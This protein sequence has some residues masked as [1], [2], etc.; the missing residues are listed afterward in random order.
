ME[1]NDVF[2]SITVTF[3][4]CLLSHVLT[5]WDPIDC[6]PQDFSVHGIFQARI[7]EWVSITSPVDFPDPGIS[8]KSVAAPALAGDNTTCE[9]HDNLTAS[10]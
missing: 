4:V 3:N 10:C 8:P 6:S 7:L 1:K 2:S 5:F 9:A